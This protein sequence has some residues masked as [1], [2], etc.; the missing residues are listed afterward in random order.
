MRHLAWRANFRQSLAYPT[1]IRST[2]QVADHEPLLESR[3][4]QPVALR[5]WRAAEAGWH[6]QA[7]H[8]RESLPAVAARA[9]RDRRRGDDRL[10]LYPDPARDRLREA[11]AAYHGWRREQVFVGNGSDEVLAHTFQ[12]LLKHDAP[13]LFPDITYSFYPVYCRLYGVALRGGAARRRDAGADRRLP[14]AVR[15]DHPAQSERAHRHCAAARCDRGAGR[16][17]IPTSWW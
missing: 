4:P 16:P 13:L 2:I 12:A 17:N 14:A 3:R 6:R 15:R 11:I 8:Q 7:Q 9:G 1:V 5:A 10:R